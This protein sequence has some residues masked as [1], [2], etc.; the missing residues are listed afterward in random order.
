MPHDAVIIAIG[1]A[2]VTSSE[3]YI[4]FYFQEAQWRR[5]PRQSA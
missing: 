4:A 5:F 1:V 2:P 3:P